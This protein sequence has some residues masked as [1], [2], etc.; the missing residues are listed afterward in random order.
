MDFLQIKNRSLANKIE[1]AIQKSALNKD[2]GFTLSGPW[3][4]FIRE[5][6]GIKIFKVQGSWIRNNLLTSW[7]HGGHGYVSEFIPL[8]E[9]WVSDTHPEYCIC[10]NV[11]EKREIS[12]KFFESSI[13][14]E[15]VE[16]ELMAKGMIYAKAHQIALQKEKEA[17]MLK[18]GYCED[19]SES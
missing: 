10:K 9:V 4:E 18:D 3:K 12:S 1:L 14:H 15:L 16:L 7:E 19:Y 5:E 2:R 17:G 11:N 6:K 8:D 13:L